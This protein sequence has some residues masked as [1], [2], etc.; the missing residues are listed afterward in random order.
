MTARVSPLVECLVFVASLYAAFLYGAHQERIA[1]EAAKVKPL[2]QSIKTHNEKAARGQLVEKT[3]VGAVAQ[4]NAVFDLLDAEV[5][6]YAEKNRA[7]T[8]CG[9]DDDGLR[10][11]RAANAGTEPTGSGQPDGSLPGTTAAARQWQA[12]RAAGEPYDGSAHLPQLPQGISGPDP[13][14]GGG[15]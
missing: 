6:K 12:G 1:C 14:D 5:K 4:N 7:A 10:L 15:R 11:W 9:L 8:D 13:L 2:E 3:T